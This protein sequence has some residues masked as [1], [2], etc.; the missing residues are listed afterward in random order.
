MPLLIVTE[1]PQ[2]EFVFSALRSGVRGVLPADVEPTELGAAIEAVAEGLLVVHPHGAE[3]LL[4]GANR[5]AESSAQALPE[6][7]TPREVEVLRLLALGVGNK[8]IAARLNISEHTVKFHVASL[9]GKLDAETRTEAV[10]TGLRLG[11]IL[12]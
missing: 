3:A 11:L 6:P 10:T 1:D 8:E 12:L 2:P 4:S 7:L 9:M 5:L